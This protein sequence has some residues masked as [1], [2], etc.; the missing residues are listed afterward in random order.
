MF[1]GQRSSC[2]KHRVCVYR[3]LP[4]LPSSSNLCFLLRINQK[5]LRK[6]ECIDPESQLGEGDRRT[7]LSIGLYAYVLPSVVT[8][9]DIGVPQVLISDIHRWD[10]ISR[11]PFQGEIRQG[12]GL[13]IPEENL[14]MWWLLCAQGLFKQ[15]SGQCLQLL[16]SKPRAGKVGYRCCVACLRNMA[17]KCPAWCSN[18]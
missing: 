11:P 5:Q 7:P 12:H 4:C 9:L 17:G 10:A 16:S 6:C 3:W 2:T 8:H 1:R 13:I 14:C 15:Q 18:V